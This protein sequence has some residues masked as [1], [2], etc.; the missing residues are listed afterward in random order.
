MKKIF[1]LLAVSLFSVSAFAQ[2]EKGAIR[3][4]GNTNLGFS[5]LK[6]DGADKSNSYFNLGVDAGYFVID[7]LSIDVGFGFEYAKA[8]G[9]DDADTGFDVN[10]GARYYLPMKVFFGAAFDFQS[11]KYG[12][13]DSVSGT[14][15]TLGAGY[16][17]FL[18][19][20]VAFEPMIGYRLGLTDK[21]KGTK[22]NAFGLQMGVSVFF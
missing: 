22:Y 14:G 8:G 18:S 5:S 9:A 21:D 20:K 6:S 13:G 2:T 4:G 16:A 7:N 11:A 15:L 19:D 3:L 17:W 12:G 10:L 1:V